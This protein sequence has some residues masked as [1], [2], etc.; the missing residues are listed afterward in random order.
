MS[1]H[2]HWLSRNRALAASGAFAAYATLL[3]IYTGGADQTWAIWAAVAYGVTTLLLLLTRRTRVPLIVPLLVSVGGALAAPLIW[4]V[5]KVQ[6]TAEVTVISQAAKLLLQHGTP[7]L[8]PG[9]LSNWDQYNPYMPFM[10]IFG[11]PK[12]LGATGLLADPR[13]WMTLM[14]VA[15]IAAAFW[16]AAPHLSCTSC[17]RNV[18]LSTVFAASSPVIA[19]P[20]AVGITDPPVIALLLVTLALAA[21]PGRRAMWAGVT[22][23]VASAM[24][25]TAW[26]AVPIVAA[27]LATRDGARAAWRIVGIAILLAGGLSVLMAP[28]AIVDPPA[29]LQNTVLFPL[30]LTRHKTPAA[31]PLPGHLLAET[32]SAGHWAAV[33]LLLVAG[34][35]FAV[36][37]IVRPPADT[38]A[39]ALR[40]ALGLAV[41]FTLAPATRYG[42]FVYPIGLIGWLALTRQAPSRA[43]SS[44]DGPGAGSGGTHTPAP[45]VAGVGA[46]AE[47]AM[48]GAAAGGP[49]RFASFALKS[50]RLTAARRRDHGRRNSGV[51]HSGSVSAGLR[52]S[53]LL[54]PKLAAARTK[55]LRT[56]CHYRTHRSCL[57]T[58]C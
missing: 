37:L 17:S 46:G 12:A 6:P 25:A 14:S 24:K 23:G 40:I 27:L 47:T 51:R 15:L 2:E 11:L 29:F 48:A 33:G 53:G 22:L 57:F 21:R 52:A 32:G 7:Y 58:K 49:G 35:G 18:A 43:S 1:V 13:I 44:E 26:P 28:A 45:E 31:S 4:L 55:E 36:S 56:A 9:S 5:D 30:G 19:F 41:M 54:P 34:I 38:R 42:Y 20:L 8:A 3:A 10:A 16:L 39:V 50:P